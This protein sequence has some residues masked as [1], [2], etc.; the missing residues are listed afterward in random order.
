[1]AKRILDLGCGQG[2]NTRYLSKRNQVIGIDISAEDIA[3]AER[4][5]PKVDFRVMDGGALQFETNYFDEIY[6]QDALEHL[7]NIESAIKE[8]KRVLNPGGRFTVTIPY[9][10]SEKWL[11][12][13]RP[14]YFEEIHHVRIFGDGELEG[15]LSKYGFTMIKKRRIGFLSHIFQYYMFKR[16]TKKK[17]QLGIGLW[18]DSWQATFLFVALLFFDTQVFKSPLKYV[19]IWIIT[20]PIGLVIN[21]FGNIFFPKT[22]YYQFKKNAN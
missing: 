10:K 7:D 15:L 9:W 19:P 16:K 20:M 21:F 12:K 2:Y 8:V 17:S 18:S 5:F 14:T 4:K 13:I 3:I 11:L 6:A 1:M 22:I